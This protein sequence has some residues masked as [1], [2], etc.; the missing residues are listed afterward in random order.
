[1]NNTPGG[2][3]IPELAIKKAPVNGNEIE[4]KPEFNL[5]AAL[6]KISQ[7]NLYRFILLSVTGIATLIDLF[8]VGF[9]DKRADTTFLVFTFLL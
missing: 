2:L 3:V 4:L 6:I 1:M 5:R 7:T 9:F 8:R